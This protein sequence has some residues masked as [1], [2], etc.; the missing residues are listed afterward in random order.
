MTTTYTPRGI[1]DMEDMNTGAICKGSWRADGLE[2]GMYPLGAPPTNA[3]AREA[4]R[5]RDE[6][7]EYF[8]TDG[9]V[10]WQCSNIAV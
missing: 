5:I 4:R 1:V 6:F 9:Q 2:D 7:C 3:Y 8:Y 10:S